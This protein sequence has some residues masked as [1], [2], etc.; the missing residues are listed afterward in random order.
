MFRE[1]ETVS[2]SGNPETFLEDPGRNMRNFAGNRMPIVNGREWSRSPD[3]MWMET[4]RE[5]KIDGPYTSMVI[6][7]NRFDGE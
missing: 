6:N 4:A 3:E 5:G 7:M 2:E 1:E